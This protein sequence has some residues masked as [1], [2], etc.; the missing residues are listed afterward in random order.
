MKTH[1][2]HAVSNREMEEYDLERTRALAAKYDID[3]EVRIDRFVPPGPVTQAF[4][5][6]RDNKTKVLMGPLGGG[7]T[8]TCAFA[9]IVA[10]TWQPIAGHPED[11]KPTRMSRWLVL[12]DTFR[13]AEKSLLESWKRWFPKSYPG[14]SWAGG[15]DRPVT[16][17]LRFYGRDGVRI[18]MIT[19]FAGLNEH[20]IETMMKGREYDGVW[21]NEL[22][23]HADGALED[24]E[25]R[26][27][28][29]PS[30]NLLLDR[31]APRN[32]IVIGDMN[33]PLIDNWTYE[34]L[35]RNVRD[36]RILYEQPS[37]T[38]DDAENLFALEPDY[39]ERL[40]A[41][42]DEE[43]AQRMVHNRFGYSRAGKAVFPSFD[44]RRHVAHQA[45]PFNP[46]LGLIVGVDT[47]INT[48]NPAAVFLQ[49]RAGRLVAIDELYA[50]EHGVGATRFAERLNQ[51]IQERYA[52][53]RTIRIF[54]DPAAEHGA[55]SEGGQLDAMQKI[56]L[57]TGFPVLMPFGGSNELGMRLDA[58][59]TE[60]RGYQ[61]PET[62]IL[63]CPKG[64]PTLIMAIEGKYRYRKKTGPGD[65]KWDDEPEKKH[66]WS[67]L[68]DALQYGIGGIRGRTAAQ[69]LA[70]GVRER[71]AG[72][73]SGPW[74]KTA[75]RGGF[76]VHRVGR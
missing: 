16:H 55:D 67:D 52:E 61:E 39:Y 70:A 2:V 28:R 29:Y 22:D 8:T 36:G 59:K 50:D 30:K 71:S 41:T 12:R 23:T 34:K 47:S 62:H 44:R 75:R 42:L 1:P 68:A 3:G 57:I 69:R 46:D 66:P 25:M 5:L 45:I 60:L 27:G 58:V 19:E 76:D 4:L 7:K 51:R 13:N 32:A 33:A 26:V 53:A 20:D 17:V 63:F 15:N 24:G 18:E 21:L 54:A 14:S 74:G 35:V 37:G 73:T 49:N 65:D 38:A 48:L 11:G 40:L 31:D 9:R 6:D 72:E 64:C 43:D 10:A 56:A